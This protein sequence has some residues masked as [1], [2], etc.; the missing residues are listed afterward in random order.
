MY[1]NN[2]MTLIRIALNLY[3]L[4]QYKIFK[5]NIYFEEE[6][7]FLQ[8]LTYSSFYLALQFFSVIF[9]NFMYKDVAQFA[10]DA[11]VRDLMSL[12]VKVMLSFNIFI[13]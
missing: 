10:L 12:M 7:I 1:K 8:S 3:I 13:F 2:A 6:L 5:K 4:I 11:D 9:F